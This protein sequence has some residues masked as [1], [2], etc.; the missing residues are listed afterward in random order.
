MATAKD[1]GSEEDDGDDE[2]YYSLSLSPTSGVSIRPNVRSFARNYLVWQSL[3]DLRLRDQSLFWEAFPS[4]VFVTAH[5]RSS[6]YSV[7]TTRL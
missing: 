6:G 7:Q 2:F 4:T 1:K 3:S 5:R